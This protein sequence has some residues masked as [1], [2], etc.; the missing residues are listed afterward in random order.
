MKIIDG[1]GRLFGRIN[2]IDLAVLVFFLMLIFIIFMG[3]KIAARRTDKNYREV[4]VKVKFIKIMPELTKFIKAGDIEK[5][6]LGKIIG[7]VK[8]AETI[9][10][11][12]SYSKKLSPP[13]GDGSVDYVVLNMGDRVM[14]MPLSENIDLMVGLD[15]TCNVEKGV[16]YYNGQPVKIGREFTLSTDLYA[17]TG[18]VVDLKLNE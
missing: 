11:N 8:S 15:I 7:T 18:Y 14:V 10:S 12:T 2:I 17:V 3:Y 5:D 13:S 4:A 6:G 16:L 1:K 9:V